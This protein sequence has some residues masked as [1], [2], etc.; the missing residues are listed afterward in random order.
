MDL[1]SVVRE[2]LVRRC[3]THTG[4]TVVVGVSGGADSLCLLH[5]LRGLQAQF[6]WSLHI[7]HLNHCLRGTESDGDMVFVEL[8]GRDWGLLCTTKTVDV[9]TVAD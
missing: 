9:A 2:N 7:A 4:A 1:P 8:L 5:V 6:Q 3:R